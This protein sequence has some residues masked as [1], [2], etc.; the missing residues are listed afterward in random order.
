MDCGLISGIIPVHLG[1][2]TGIKTEQLTNN[3]K[4]EILLS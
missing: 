2:M 1:I 4:C 3:E